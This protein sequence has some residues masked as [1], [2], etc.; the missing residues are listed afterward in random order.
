MTMI[1]IEKTK[2]RRD[3]IKDGLKGKLFAQIGEN[4]KYKKIK[5]NKTI[6]PN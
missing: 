6:K 1:K 2:K 4:G 3:K 5:I